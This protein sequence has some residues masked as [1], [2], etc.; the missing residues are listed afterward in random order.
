MTLRLCQFSGVSVRAGEGAAGRRAR[1]KQHPL[2][3]TAA[4]AVEGESKSSWSS[5]CSVLFVRSKKLHGSH[6][7]QAVNGKQTKWLRWPYTIPANQQVPSGARKG[8]VSFN[9]LLRSN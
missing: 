3:L 9:W 5:S 6:P 4:D 1:G 2:A 7:V 8:G